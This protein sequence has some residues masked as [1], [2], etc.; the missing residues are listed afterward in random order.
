[1]NIKNILAVSAMCGATFT[2]FADGSAEAPATATESASAI[3]SLVSNANAGKILD[4][5]SASIGAAFESEF[6]FRGKQLAG[7]AVSPSAEV[8]FDAGKG[9]GAYA[10]WWGC[11]SADNS[12]ALGE[13]EENDIYCGVTYSLENLTADFGYT[14]YTYPAS[15][16]ANEHE[17]KFAL[18][19][20]T[21]EFLGDFALSPY[22]AFYYNFTYSGTTIEAGLT[23]SAPVTAWVLGE[24]WGTLDFNFFGAYADYKLGGMSDGGYAYAGFSADAVVKITEIWSFSAG[25]RY[26]ANNDSLGKDSLLWYGLGTSLAF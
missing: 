8:G 11:Y 1:M 15:G 5:F 10:G 16:S 24:E 3:T 2:A 22:A 21:S 20:D 4:R 18:S 9:F 25:I 17:L 6:V 19:Y 12:N 14:A 13:Y 26:A 7:P 23:Y